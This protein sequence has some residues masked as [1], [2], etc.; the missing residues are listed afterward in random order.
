MLSK[1]PCHYVP[2]DWLAP[3]A[4]QLSIALL[5]CRDRLR[6]AGTAQQV[7]MWRLWLTSCVLI[8]CLTPSVGLHSKASQ[9]CRRCQRLNIYRLAKMLLKKPNYCALVVWLFQS[10]ARNS[11][12]WLFYHCYQRLC[13]CH[14]RKIP[15]IIRCCGAQ[16]VSLAV[17]VVE[18]PIL[19][20]SD[21]HCQKPNICCLA[22]MPLKLH[23]HCA[24]TRS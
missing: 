5:C 6:P 15:L 12:A 18:N 7:K 2:V 23:R 10:D 11:R 21:H 1:E 22:R 9:S 17:F 24:L 3:S 13:I 4:A 19:W 14:Q 8:L 16:T 20:L